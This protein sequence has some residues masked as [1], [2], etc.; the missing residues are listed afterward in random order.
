MTSTLSLLAAPAPVVAP[1]A[2]LPAVVAPA[3]ALAATVA[4]LA[5]VEPVAVV[6][7]LDLLLLPQAANISEQASASDINPLRCTCLRESI[8]TWLMVDLRRSQNIDAMSIQ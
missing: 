4:P 8:G 3:A 7:P 1:V 2:E 5:T 6:V